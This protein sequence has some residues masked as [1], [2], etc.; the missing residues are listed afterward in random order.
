MNK[1]K[2]NKHKC[3]FSGY[4]NRV[5]ELL[6]RLLEFESNADQS[7]RQSMQDGMKKQNMNE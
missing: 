4:I 2:T 5:G 3:N 1:F 6:E 7:S